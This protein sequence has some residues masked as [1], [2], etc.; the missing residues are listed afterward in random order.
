M[1]NTEEILEALELAKNGLLWY[2]DNFPG[3]VN[4]CD[5]EA[6]E[7]INAAIATYTS[8]N[9][10]VVNLVKAAEEYMEAEGYKL[11]EE[12]IKSREKLF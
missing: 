6:M 1:K 9:K 3:I 8:Q 10:S 11:P 12:A 4:N 2:Q 5:T 7:K